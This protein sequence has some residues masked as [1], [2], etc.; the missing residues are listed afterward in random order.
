MAKK[1]KK[2]KRNPPGMGE[3]LM[4]VNPTSLNPKKKKYKRNPK[5]GAGA[6][7]TG[8]FDSQ[9]P[10][11]LGAMGGGAFASRFATAKILG[12]KDVGLAS[13]GTQVGIGF[14]G[15]TALKMFIKKQAV[16][17]RFFF[18]GSLFHAGWRLLST[19][20]LQANL[21]PGFEYGDI[22]R[23]APPKEAAPPAEEAGPGGLYYEREEEEEFA[24]V[25]GA[26]DDAY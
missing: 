9:F 1:K 20:I 15:G 5:W 22:Y 25:G 3:A 10:I 19:K 7:I 24:G 17:G 6:L 23:E 18:L 14:V 4:V 8:M 26:Y 12:D 13:V 2:Y 21:V 16:I 11:Q